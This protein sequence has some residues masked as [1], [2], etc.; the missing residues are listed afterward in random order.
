M[1]QEFWTE[2]PHEGAPEG[3]LGLGVS[4]CFICEDALAIYREA[5]RRGLQPSRPFVGN[6]MWDVALSDPD[7]YGL[8]F[9]SDTDVPEETVLSEGGE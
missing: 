1:L 9:E 8:H 6:G 2:G 5:K 7:G 4:I 3:K